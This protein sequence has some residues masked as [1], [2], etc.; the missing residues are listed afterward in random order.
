MDSMH[1]YYFQKNITAADD[2]RPNDKK[3]SI[4]EPIQNTILSKVNSRDLSDVLQSIPMPVDERV[5]ALV[6][7]YRYIFLVRGEFLIKMETV[8]NLVILKTVGNYR[9]TKLIAGADGQHIFV[10]KNGKLIKLNFELEIVR[11]PDDAENTGL[12][13]ARL[14]EGSGDHLYIVENDNLI[15][16]DAITI[17]EV[18]RDTGWTNATLLTVPGDSFLYIFRDEELIKMFQYTLK[19]FDKST[20]WK[21][22]T[23]LT[24]DGRT[25]YL[26]NNGELFAVNGNKLER[27]DSVTPDSDKDNLTLISSWIAY[28]FYVENV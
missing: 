19:Y 23:G 16:M 28:V 15:Q 5:T 22:A 18:N 17:R 14:M 8:P 21:S 11:L 9:D 27:D 26:V 4:I 7:Y 1:P 6:A 3:N 12:E 24:G 13:G 20:E 25:L 2:L 10:I